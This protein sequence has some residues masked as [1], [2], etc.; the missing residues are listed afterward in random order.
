MSKILIIED[1]KVLLD[2]LEKKLASQGYEIETA[3]DGESG[4]DEMRQVRPDLILLDIVMPKKDGFEVLAEMDKDK[5][6]SGI[7]VIIISNSGQSVEIDK[8]LKFGVRDYLIKTE[9]DPEEVL[10]KIVKVLGPAPLKKAKNGS[11][12]G[13]MVGPKAVFGAPGNKILIVEDDKFL[14][15][16]II[17]KLKTE[18][19]ET[20]FAKEGEEALKKIKEESPTL[21]LLD[22][23]LPGIDGF[24]V[25]KQLKSN[26]SETLR[27]IPVI[28]LS[29]LGQR[30]DVER[31]INAGAVD[32]LVKAHFTPGEI[33]EKIKQVLTIAA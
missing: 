21:I 24:E 9:F 15:D 6:L 23:I 28:I 32:F 4:L 17:R 19:Y 20:S 16:L 18:G 29:N 11:Y 27:K 14:R 25:L 33:V 30:D 3:S 8:A 13:G 26:S 2:V 10:E 12:Q 31:G 7:P 22:L 5:S 1:E